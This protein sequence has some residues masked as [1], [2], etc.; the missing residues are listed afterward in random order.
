MMNKKELAQKFSNASDLIDHICE[1]L[2]IDPEDL[3]WDLGSKTKSTSLVSVSLFYSQGGGEGEGSYAIRVFKVSTLNG[4]VFAYVGRTGFYDSWN[5]TDWEK[6]TYML[7]KEVLDYSFE[8][9]VSPV[10]DLIPLMR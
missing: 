3:S 9:V 7:G 2:Q 8:E 1:E 4:E 10:D 5:G 6:W